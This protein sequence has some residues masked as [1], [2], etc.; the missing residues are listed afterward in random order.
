MMFVEQ[1][2][3]DADNEEEE[4]TDSLVSTVLEALEKLDEHL[5]E[6]SGNVSPR[7]QPY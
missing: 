7:Y 2:P 3:H 4:N 1:M 5:Q 6:S